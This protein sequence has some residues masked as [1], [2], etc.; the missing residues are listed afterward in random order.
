M[1]RPG[2]ECRFTVVDASRIVV[3]MCFV[4]YT[5]S[6]SRFIWNSFLAT[7]YP[8]ILETGVDIKN[9][10]IFDSSTFTLFVDVFTGAVTAMVQMA[11]S[12]LG[13]FIKF[14][15]VL[16]CDNWRVE[17]K[18]NGIIQLDLFE[19]SGEVIFSKSKTT[20]LQGLDDLFYTIIDLPFDSKK[21]PKIIPTPKLPTK[22]MKH[23]RHFIYFY[24]RGY[25]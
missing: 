13:S 25:F 20:S 2:A 5:A 9:I 12:N 17:S 7:V 15:D 22:Q 14:I 1:Q 18:K 10:K 21:L 8:A 3:V 11:R 16:K 19:N 23:L 4:S 24:L 6:W